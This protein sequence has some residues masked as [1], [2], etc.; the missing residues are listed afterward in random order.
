MTFATNGNF[1][2]PNFQGEGELNFG[3]RIAIKIERKCHWAIALPLT[4]V[5]LSNSDFALKLNKVVKYDFKT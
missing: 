4:K 3:S 2:R 5:A 1:Q